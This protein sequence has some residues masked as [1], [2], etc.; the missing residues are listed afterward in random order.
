MIRRDI[1]HSFPPPFF[2]S[3]ELIIVI[4]RHRLGPIYSNKWSCFA[5]SLKKMN[6]VLNVVR[7]SRA[8]IDASKLFVP[9]LAK[10]PFRAMGLEGWSM[11]RGGGRR[12]A[13]ERFHCRGTSNRGI[14]GIV[15]YW[16]SIQTATSSDPIRATS[17]ALGTAR[18]LPLAPPRPSRC[19][20]TLSPPAYWILPH[21]SGI[22][23]SRK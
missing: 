14:M 18:T 19:I 9:C 8:K 15:W 20:F 6:R 5:R 17:S 2:F 10:E 7:V 4:D 21:E 16:I 11:G 3:V 23:H 13:S 12:G 22:L 1:F